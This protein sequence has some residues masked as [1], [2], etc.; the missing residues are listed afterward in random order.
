MVWSLPSGC[1]QAFASIILAMACI[2]AGCE[3][4][5]YSHL[6]LATRFTFSWCPSRIILK[7]EQ[8]RKAKAHSSQGGKSSGRLLSC[9]HPQCKAHYLLSSACKTKEGMKT[10]HLCQITN[11]NGNKS[12]KVYVTIH[13]WEFLKVSAMASTLSVGGSARSTLN[14]ANKHRLCCCLLNKKRT[15][16]DR[17]T[18]RSTALT[19]LSLMQWWYCSCIYGARLHKFL[20]FTRCSL[21]L[22]SRKPRA[23]WLSSGCGCG[24]C[25]LRIAGVTNLHQIT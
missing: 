18:A 2:F 19:S 13:F 12:I 10:W 17:A 8:Q 1:Y 25:H 23:F 4:W 5:G 16:A 20:L 9:C 24:N 6:H 14:I 21:H 7:S 15:S 3:V 11:L 22:C